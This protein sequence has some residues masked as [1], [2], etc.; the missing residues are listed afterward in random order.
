MKPT[1]ESKLAARMLFDAYRKRGETKKL[2]SFSE[3]GVGYASGYSEAIR[4]LTDALKLIPENSIMQIMEL[5]LKV[6]C[7]DE[8]A[9][10]HWSFVKWCM[11]TGKE[12]E[13]FE[14]RTLKDYGLED[15][16][17]EDE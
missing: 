2:K 5:A 17:G 7:R 1:K 9:D 16:Y 14:K 3:F 6:K 4:D 12:A 15:A 8:K 13:S 11:P 10:A